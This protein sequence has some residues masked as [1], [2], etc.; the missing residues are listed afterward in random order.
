MYHLKTGYMR[1]KVL[2]SR[3]IITVIIILLTAS[4]DGLFD[5]VGLSVYSGY[6]EIEVPVPPAEAG[7]HEF[8]Q[9]IIYTD[10]EEIL[11]K[12][13][14]Q[15]KNV[16]QIKVHELNLEVMEKSV[17]KNFDAVDYLCA[18]IVKGTEYDT[19]AY[20]FDIPVNGTA[21]SMDIV[22]NNVKDYLLTEDYNIMMTGL[23][24]EE[25][26]DTLWVK[27]MVKYEIIL[28]IDAD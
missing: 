16:K 13:G 26:K 4:C 12:E 19:V 9:N 5:D 2:Y 11:E 7:Y 6:Y 15:G 1:T 10:V 21:I 18:E 28:G 22:K 8:S 14:Q 27:G 20:S 25:L 24:R 3:I 17:I 23:L